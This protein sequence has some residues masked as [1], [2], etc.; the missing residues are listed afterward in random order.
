MGHCR[1]WCLSPLWSLPLCTLWVF[2]HPP[3]TEPSPAL[4]GPSLLSRAPVRDPLTLGLPQD[5]LGGLRI[6]VQEHELRSALG[7]PLW[8]SPFL[9]LKADLGS[10]GLQSPGVVGLGPREAGSGSPCATD[11]PGPDG[12]MDSWGGAKGCLQPDSA[13][14][15][16]T[17]AA[18]QDDLERRLPEEAETYLGLVFSWSPGS[19]QERG[20]ECLGDTLVSGRG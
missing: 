18:L 15:L 2:P 20:T 9:D 13:V 10:P 5:A 12:H 17:Q 3:I 4:P 19:G 16:I 14:Q 8:V 11:H 7:Q 1:P 6:G